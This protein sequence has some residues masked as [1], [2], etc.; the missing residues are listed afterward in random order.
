MMSAVSY[1][2]SSGVRGRL[3]LRGP[4]LAKDQSGLAA[5]KW[6]ALREE[7]VHVAI[8]QIDKD[9]LAPELRC[10][11]AT[12]TA[13]ADHERHVRPPLPAGPPDVGWLVR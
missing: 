7:G 3:A 13:R 10:V 8:Q 2:S 11:A 4:M 5:E 9:R 1:A 12:C 6:R